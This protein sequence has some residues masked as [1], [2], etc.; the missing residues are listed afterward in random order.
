M[1]PLCYLR[2]E[3]DPH[4]THDAPHPRLWKSSMTALGFVLSVGGTIVLIS[5]PPWMGGTPGAAYV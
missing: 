3:F 2:A 1:S 5:T 4:D